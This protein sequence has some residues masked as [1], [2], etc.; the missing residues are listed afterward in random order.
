MADFSSGEGEWIAKLGNLRNTIRQE[1]IARQLGEHLVDR[2]TG[3]TITVLDVGCGQG[4]QGLRLLASGCEVTGI[5]PSPALLAQFRE[6]AAAAG[7]AVELF[8]GSI[9][10]A[11]KL[12]DERTFDVVCAHGLFM[13]LDDPADALRTLAAR[14]SDGGL[15]S[16]TVKNRHGQALRPALRGNWEAC[17]AAF[18]EVRYENELGVDARAD[19][20]DDVEEWVAAA[21]LEID[22]WY[23]VRFFNDGIA[24]DVL[25]PE[26]GSL[27][28]LLDAEDRAGRT[29]P[30]RWLGSQLHVIAKPA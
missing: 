24:G 8:E 16:F 10:D 13:Y 9:G 21:N 25:A 22:T 6:D 14:V 28:A 18:D 4:T 17:V 27:P 3:Q 1:L 2:R 23:G 26:D 29:D 20:L 30:Y 15:V 5:D 7:H 11:P 12:L 19:R